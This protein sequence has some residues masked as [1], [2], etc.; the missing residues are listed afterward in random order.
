MGSQVGN[1]VALD[2]F[3]KLTKIP[4]RI[5]YSD[6]IPTSPSPYPRL[7]NWRNRVALGTLMV[8]AINQN[9]G[10]AS[11]L[12]LPDVGIFGNTHFSFSDVNNIQIADLLSH[13]LSEKHLDR[14]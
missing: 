9:G 7:E 8:S 11:I 6:H 13:W 14:R 4:I 10:D 12:D 5:Q 3:L 2:D 1:P